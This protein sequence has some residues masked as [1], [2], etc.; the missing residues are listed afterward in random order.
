VGIITEIFTIFPDGNTILEPKENQIWD[1]IAWA[2]K[3]QPT[4]EDL[5][6]AEIVRLEAQ[7]TER[8][9]REAILGIDNGWLRK[10]NDLITQIALTNNLRK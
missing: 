9:Q 8:R 10:Q 6:K 1:G 2:D 4:T 7:V 3:P 5:I